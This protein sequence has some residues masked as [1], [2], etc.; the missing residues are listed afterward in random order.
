[1]ACECNIRCAR[2]DHAL[3]FDIFRVA[4]DRYRFAVCRALA[5]N[6]DI[7]LN[8][9][10]PH[11]DRVCRVVESR[12]GESA[13]KAAV[14]SRRVHRQVNCRVAPYVGIF[15]AVREIEPALIIIHCQVDSRVAL[16]D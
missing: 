15:H 13:V 8:A 12:K 16:E 9:A 14:R 1:M 6:K 3:D 11:P 10:L 7:S 4:V 5:V 2:P